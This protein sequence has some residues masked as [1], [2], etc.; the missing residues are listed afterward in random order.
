[1][2]S[3][4]QLAGQESIYAIDAF[5]ATQISAGR[6]DPSACMPT[7]FP[8][9]FT[10]FVRQSIEGM[11]ESLMNLRA[12]SIAISGALPPARLLAM[13]FTV[14]PFLTASL[15]SSTVSSSIE[16]WSMPAI[17]LSKGNALA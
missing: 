12:I 17:V 11:G 2:T 4:E 9:A 7:L 3:R 13:T 14:T 8:W 5:S 15:I 6:L 10:R 1:M 16:D